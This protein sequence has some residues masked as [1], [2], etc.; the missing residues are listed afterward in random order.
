MVAQARGAAGLAVQ[1]LPARSRRRPSGSTAASSTARSRACA[2]GWRAPSAARGDRGDAGHGARPP[3]RRRPRELRGAR[4]DA[5]ARPAWPWRSANA[6]NALDVL[7]Q[8]IQ[9]Q[10][11]RGGLGG[12]LGQRDRL[13]AGLRLLRAGGLGGRDHRRHG[14]AGAH[15]LADRRQRRRPGRPGA[16]RRGERQRR[17]GRGRGGGRR[18]SRRSRSGSAAS[19]AAPRS[20]APAPRRSTGCST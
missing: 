7:A 4:R 13:G 18:A 3:A 16:A 2:S 5:P 19:P 9:A 12:Q 15:R 17:P 1:R 11:D 6:T 10:L 8:Q 14:G 20:W